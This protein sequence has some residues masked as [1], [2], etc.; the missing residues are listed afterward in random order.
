MVFV[1]AYCVRKYLSILKFQIIKYLYNF[2][3]LNCISHKFYFERPAVAP[4]KICV[5]LGSFCSS[6]KTFCKK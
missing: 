5:G 2:D 1:C 3:V 4:E 6:G